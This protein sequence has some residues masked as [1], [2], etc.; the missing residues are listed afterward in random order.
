MSRKRSDKERKKENETEKER[1]E[2]KIASLENISPNENNQDIK[3]L[4]MSDLSRIL[5]KNMEFNTQCKTK[6]KFK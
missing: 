2:R 6:T 1:E 5:A 3:S 4:H